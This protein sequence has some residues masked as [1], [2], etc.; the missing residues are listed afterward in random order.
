MAYTPGRGDSISPSGTVAF[1][2]K[3]KDCD[4]YPKDSGVLRFATVLLNEGG[5][6]SPET[7]IF[8]CPTG[9]LYHFTLHASVYG[10]VQCAIFKNGGTV[11]SLYHTT[12]PDKCS[13]VAS[14]SCVVK[15]VEN[16][17]VW[18]NMWGPG[19]NDIFATEDNDTVFVGVRV[20]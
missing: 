14:V 9:G 16:D 20:G 2:A 19:R 4:S 1:T 3:L 7:G 5:G 15:L 10:R 8:T 18:V 12:L 17:T 6:Y 11:V 13:Q